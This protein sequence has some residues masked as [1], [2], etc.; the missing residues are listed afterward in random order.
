[1]QC[2]AQVGTSKYVLCL[3]K[4]DNFHKENEFHKE[5]WLLSVGFFD[6]EF[7]WDIL[8]SQIS[9]YRLVW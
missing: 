2:L 1:M 9:F 3:W 7:V 6:L 5:K 8:I 4:E